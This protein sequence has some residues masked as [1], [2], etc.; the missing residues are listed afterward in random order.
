MEEKGEKRPLSYYVIPF[1]KRSSTNPLEVGIYICILLILQDDP[2]ES[3][4]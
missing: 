1:S 2:F 3:Q 4:P